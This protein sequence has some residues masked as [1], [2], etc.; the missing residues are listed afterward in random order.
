MEIAA[1]FVR[2]EAGNTI[3]AHMGVSAAT[4]YAQRRKL[5]TNSAAAASGS[6]GGDSA[7]KTRWS[8]LRI[9][10]CSGSRWP[11]GRALSPTHC[12]KGGR[13]YRYYVAQTVLKGDGSAS[14]D[15]VRRI[16]AAEIEALVI[17]QVRAL[18]RQP[19]IV[20]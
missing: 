15:I 20:V 14:D 11:D 6:Q 8:A 1:A 19:E 10:C 5:M 18:L 7:L 3:A 2:G 12:R 17:D 16:P 4:I 13:L 9:G